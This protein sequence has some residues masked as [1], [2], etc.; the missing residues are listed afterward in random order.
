MIIPT[1]P[2]DQDNS[3]FYGKFFI[4]LPTTFIFY[5][6]S[7]EQLRMVEKFSVGR[8]LRVDRFAEGY[9]KFKNTMV[10]GFNNS[11]IFTVVW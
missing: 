7:N 5:N 4:K 11:Q 10:G 1:K 2:V 9:Y 6:F 3:N 8:L